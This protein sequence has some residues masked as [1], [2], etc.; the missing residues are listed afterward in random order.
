VTRAGRAVGAGLALAAGLLAAAYGRSVWTAVRHPLNLGSGAAW[1][2]AV[3]AVLAAVAATA[4]LWSSAWRVWLALEAAAAAGM[5]AASGRAGSALAAA[6]TLLVAASAGSF[7]SRRAGLSSRRPLPERL[8]VD[9]PLGLA[10][11]AVAVFALGLLQSLNRASLALLAAALLAPGARRLPDLRRALLRAGRAPGAR[12]RPATTDERVLLPALGILFLLAL[13]WALAPEIQFDALNYHLAVPAIQLREG[14]LRAHPEFWH[15]YLAHLVEALLAF[16]LAFGGPIAAKLVVPA[17]AGLAGLATYALGRRAYGRRAGLWA[18]ALFSTT[19]LAAWLAS[20]AYVDDAAAMFLTA[21]LV[22]FLGGRRTRSAS[23]L[24]VSGMLAGAA[25]G[26]KLTALFALPVIGVVLA[27]R[28]W[29]AEGRRRAAAEAL[30]FGAGFALLA[31]PW[32]AWTW[33]L[34]GSP[35]YP[36]PAPLFRLHGVTPRNPLALAAQFGIGS[37]W[38]GW[39]RLPFALSFESGKFGEAL[40][41]GAVGIVPAL[42]VPAAIAAI[43]RR[44]RAGLLL[45]GL[46]AVDFALWG[47]HFQYA[48]LL[49]PVLPVAAVLAA[50]GLVA[51]RRDRL[52]GSRLR[53]A[54]AFGAVA[55]QCALLPSLYW[56]IP[57]RIPWKVALGRET[58]ERFLDRALPGI[59]AVRALNPRLRPGDRVAGVAVERLRF[60][61]HAPLETL[62]ESD[63]LQATALGFHNA[64]LRA[65][66]ESAGYR[67]LLLPAGNPTPVAPY[68]IPE[69]LERFADPVFRGPA[70][71]VYRLRV[72][73]RGSP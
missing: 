18:A 52:P 68:Q 69:F 31:A 36:F 11:L 60:Y 56:Q 7:A 26:T 57:E 38:L 46:F 4:W 29:P 17:A 51:P 66:L 1:A 5:I 43:W 63:R 3:L 27:A 22:A 37:G 45:L 20:T 72:R 28:L 35:V 59:E 73:D 8:A 19:P 47:A 16:P 33:S 53:A 12:R 65:R 6:A 15:S 10:L 25:A 41:P 13:A 67:F 64:P 14:G 54:A 2:A 23:S 70:L 62:P 24:A 58:P 9:V 49:V 44:S 61:V 71:S 42:L 21:A 55:A 30:A 40:G 34:T 32:Y 50:G 39:V 48:R